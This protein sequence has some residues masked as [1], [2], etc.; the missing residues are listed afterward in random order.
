[1]SNGLFKV[2][3]TSNKSISLVILLAA[4][5]AIGLGGIANADINTKS[6]TIKTDKGITLNIMGGKGAKG[7]AGPAGPAGPAGAQ[8]ETG[9]A[10]PEGA[11][12][13]QGPAG[14][15]GPAGA[16]GAV[17][18]AGSE[19]PM[20]PAGPQGNNG[21]VT[22]ICFDDNNQTIACPFNEPP[23]VTPPT[24]TTDNQ[25]GD[26]GNTTEPVQCQPGTHDEN[27]TC[28]VDEVIPPVTNETGGN[29]TIPI[30][31]GTVI[32]DNGTVI[33][34]NGTVVDENSTG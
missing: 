33:I 7:D 25:T 2:M 8:G 5:A 6:V 29:T 21:T 9:P 28:V 11:A 1:L 30:N 27:G 26:G 4:V 3:L 32:V 15:Q 22:F 18:P 13:L 23:V 17:G 10:G 14:S 16:D 24:N 34:D 19:G 20:G 31:N 12:G